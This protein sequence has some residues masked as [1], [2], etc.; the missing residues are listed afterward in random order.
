M[1]R[2][3]FRYVFKRYASLAAGGAFGPRLQDGELLR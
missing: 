2:K 1:E 3:P